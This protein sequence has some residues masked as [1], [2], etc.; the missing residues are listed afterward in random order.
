MGNPTSTKILKVGIYDPY[1][2]TLGG[3]ERY[4]LTIAEILASLGYQVDIFWSG[5]QDLLKKAEI[6]FGL[7]LSNINF[8]TDIFSSK[9]E[10]M[11]I[12]EDPESLVLASQHIHQQPHKLSSLYRKYLVTRQYNLFFYLS[13]WSVPFLFSKNNFLHV[14]VPFVSKIKIISRLLNHL[15]CLFIKQIICNSQF[16][17]K[18]AS[19]HFS[20]K[21]LVLYPPVDV[22]KFDPHIPKKN[23]ILSVGRFDNILNSKKQEILIVA[24]RDLV[25]HNQN[26]DWRLILAGGSIAL[27]QNNNYLR[28]LQ[29][30]AEGL[31]IDFIVNPNFTVL[32]QIYST[33]KIYWHAAGFGV[34][35]NAHPENTEHFGMAPVEAM[36]SGCVPILVNRGGL[37]EIISDNCE[38]YLWTDVSQLIAKT[39]LLMTSTLTLNSMSQASIIK[40]NHYSPWR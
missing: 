20:S 7:N 14:Q 40:S 13:D 5:D 12:A 10:T 15:K 8:V 4:C 25:L 2:D 37:S 6:R 31:P 21:Q 26:T 34:D 29:H 38:G 28:H 24:F 3:G 9:T 36:A 39:Q 33:S 16:T 1:L 35:E 32:K 23:Q 19:R 22:E 18:F 17:A 11:D 27:S 30:L